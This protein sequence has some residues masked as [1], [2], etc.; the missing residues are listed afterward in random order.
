[1]RDENERRVRG[2]RRRAHERRVDVVVGPV[3]V[4]VHVGDALDDLA[5]ARIALRA[6]EGPP[7]LVAVHPHDG[8][9]A[10]VHGIGAG[11]QH[12]DAESAAQPGLIERLFPEARALD[13]R[14]AERLGN[15]RI[16]IVRD[17]LPEAAVRV[18]WIHALEAVT[19]DPSLFERSLDRL[20]VVLERDA[21][22]ADARIERHAAGSRRQAAARTR[23]AGGA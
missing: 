7:A 10:R 3:A 22:E 21:E 1:M 2:R 11:G 20:R 18:V 6:A 13:C 19:R 16:D 17:R 23:C 14:S 4:R 5:R 8:V 12:L 15:P 9:V